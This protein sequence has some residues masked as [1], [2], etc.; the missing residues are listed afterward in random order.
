MRTLLQL[1]HWREEGSLSERHL[2]DIDAGTE[3]EGMDRACENC[4]DETRKA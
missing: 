2:S 1:A 4:S 3:F